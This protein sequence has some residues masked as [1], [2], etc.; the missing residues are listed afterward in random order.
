MTTRKSLVSLATAAALAATL[1]AP[2]FADTLGVDASVGASVQTTPASARVH[3]GAHASSTAMIGKII[4]R[5][6]DDI[7]KRIDSLNTV[8]ARVQ[9]MKNISD[10]QKATFAATI[11]TEI[12]NLTSLKATIDASTDVTTLRADAKSVM[13]AYRVYALVIPQ[14]YLEAAADRVG[15]I[16]STLTTISAKLQTRIT[17]DQTAGKDVTSLQA[18]LTDMNAKLT[19]A[20]AQA[21]AATNLVASLTPDNG[22]TTVAASNKAALLASR[23]D[24]KIASGDLNAARQDAK[25]IVAGIKSLDGKASVSATSSVSES[26]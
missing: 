20:Q 6:D 26:Q 8:A 23:A 22:N 1:V 21:T 3:V 15:T 19:D 24:I 2:V 4:A 17:T 13:D 25:T 12:A 18:S 9:G 7:S 10:A 14:G 16:T 11:Q 5:S